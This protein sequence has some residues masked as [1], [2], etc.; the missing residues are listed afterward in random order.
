[1]CI[2]QGPLQLAERD[3]RVLMDQLDEK[4]VVRSQ[5]PMS[6]IARVVGGRQAQPAFEPLRQ[7]RCRRR[8]NHQTA[9]NL[10]ACQTLGK[11]QLKTGTNIGGKRIGHELILLNRV[12]QKTR[13]MGIPYD[14][15]KAGTALAQLRVM[16]A[17]ET[18]RTEALGG[19]VAA[20]IKCHHE[21]IAYN[22]CK[23]PALPQ[24][25]GTSGA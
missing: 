12:N 3:V 20:R 4:I 16:S 13:L 18:C 23:K 7:T 17:I 21:H 15:T 19:H 6:G 2:G 11:E 14:S 25:P 5:P 24:M 10:A 9:T 8:R 22:S 1:M